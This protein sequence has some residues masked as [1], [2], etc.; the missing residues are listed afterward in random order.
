[1]F[2][3]M[4]GLNPREI[5]WICPT[6]RPRDREHPAP[7]N[8]TGARYS[9]GMSLEQTLRDKLTAAIKARDL[10]AANVIRMINTKVMERRTAK[11]FKGEV[12]D[13][14]HIEVIAAYKKSLEKAKVEYEAAG[15][16]GRLQA[17]ELAFEIEYCAQFLPAGMSD[18]ELRSAVKEVIAEMGDVNPRMAG[19]V[20]GAVMKKHKGRTEAGAVK[21]I[22]DEVL[23]G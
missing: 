1:M 9:P 13:A 4:L 2:S 12:D 3:V 16:R 22:V 8:S 7:I 5:K 6:E 20:V 17:E 15:E 14:L 10:R 23:S 21:K 11:D 19:R 18:D